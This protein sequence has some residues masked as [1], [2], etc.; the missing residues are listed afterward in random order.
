MHA[1]LSFEL[2]Y[3]GH[4][5][6][7]PFLRAL[8]INRVLLHAYGCI[9]SQ[10]FLAHWNSTPY[11]AELLTYCSPCCLTCRLA[12]LL[13]QLQRTALTD[14]LAQLSPTAGDA[15]SLSALSAALMAGG[16]SLS[17]TYTS[18][19][20]AGSDSLAAAAALLQGTPSS[21]GLMGMLDQQQQLYGQGPNAADAAA[22]L[23]S[24]LSNASQLS[25]L[26]GS[27]PVSATPTPTAA[28][29]PA[30]VFQQ[31]R[32]STPAEQ[33]EPAPQPPAMPP[34]SQPL[35]PVFHPMLQQ[36]AVA[37]GGPGFRADILAD[38]TGTGSPT[39]GASWGGA[40][41]QGM[42]SHQSALAQQL[43]QHAGVG[44]P[45]PPPPVHV[46]AS[47]AGS[48]EKQVGTPVKMANVSAAC[49]PCVSRVAMH[50][51]QLGR[52]FPV[53][54]VLPVS[55]RETRHTPGD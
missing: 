38:A 48:T 46:P 8:S 22:L 18:G 25:G 36:K 50:M 3:S 24:R 49:L 47:R 53:P 43:K 9:F 55:L 2:C 10:S 11:H 4:H 17:P 30:T 54:P 7:S 6:T 41:S 52:H 42:S 29:M 12:A 44:L 32:P 35:M 34:K 21:A 39:I 37:V 26:P 14:S 1:Q 31:H 5:S 23:H 28:G 16:G 51:Q 13:E 40:T 45:P 27:A 33:A 19:L 20:A 15:A